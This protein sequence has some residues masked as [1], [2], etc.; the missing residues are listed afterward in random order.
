[1]SYKDWSN[2]FTCTTC[3]WLRNDDET[4]SFA[5]SLLE[6]NRYKAAEWLKKT[7]EKTVLSGEIE[8]LAENLLRDALEQVNWLEV[9]EN[10]KE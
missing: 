6:K 1:M 10:L 4:S 9:V 2:K 3:Y 7:V 5:I 8:G